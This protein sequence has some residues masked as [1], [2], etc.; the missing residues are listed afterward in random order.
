MKTFPSLTQFNHLRKQ[1]KLP[2]ASI[3]DYLKSKRK[4][5]GGDSIIL[6][7][8]KMSLPVHASFSITPKDDLQSIKPVTEAAIP[9]ELLTSDASGS[10]RQD[11]S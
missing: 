5:N 1:N 3:P 11:W 4:F 7:E 6:Y 10:L 8:P 9:D 2:P